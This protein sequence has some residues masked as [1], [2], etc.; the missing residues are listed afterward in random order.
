MR[1]LLFV[2]SLFLISLTSC[3][4]DFDTVP[5][6]GQLSFSKD[7]VYL[8]TVFT[9]V[10]SS[11]YRLKVYNKSDK[12]I[13]I[14]SIVLGKNENSKYRLMVDGMTGEKGQGKVFRNVELLAND[15]LYVLIEETAGVLDTNASNFLYTD[16]IL[17]DTGA[18]Q[19][20][21]DLVTLIQDAYFLYPKKNQEYLELNDGDK[22]SRVY[23]FELDENDPLNGNELHMT[24]KKPYVIYGYAGV[25]A[26]KKLVIDAGAR[27]HFHDQSG[28]FV[29]KT[30]TIEV[31][32]QVSKDTKKMENEVVFEGDRLEPGF[33]EIAGQ[34]G[35]IYLADGS[36][37]NSFNHAT[38]KN[39]SMGIFVD[40]NDGTTTQIK[41]TQI[42]NCSDF[43]LI[44]RKGKVYGENIVINKCG[45][46]SF[47]CILG[48]NYE[49]NSCTFANFW[50]NGG[51]QSPAVYLDNTYKQKDVLYVSNLE[52][53]NFVNCIIY[54]NNNVEVGLKKDDA[55]AFNFD[56]SNCLIKFIDQA[57]V[58]KTAMYDFVKKAETKQNLVTNGQVTNDPKFV[59]AAKNNLKITKNSSVIGKGNSSFIIV[60]DIEGK[61]R[62]LPPDL[63]AYQHLE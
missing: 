25:P 19:Q 24:N 60:N 31:N 59:D 43:G 16:Q 54:G 3:R 18:N 42:Y 9:G 21:V 4:K 44:A 47:A 38:I 5:S 39:G 36:T 63:G 13:T 27:I 26:T 56:F 49:F 55:V 40:R 32:G 50:S 37:N 41:N 52:K 11:T 15:S 1:Y 45:Q 2:V 10:A 53:A 12:D 61:L 35:V 58:F 57:N 46:S 29:K 6:N 20:K 22:D 23:G 51:R 17:F 7:T 34:W 28:I 30:A 8:D 48:G 62:T 33:S 14:P